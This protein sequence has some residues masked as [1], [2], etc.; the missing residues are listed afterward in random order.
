MKKLRVKAGMG[1][2]NCSQGEE[3]MKFFM[4]LI[5]IFT[6]FCSII[7]AQGLWKYRR[8]PLFSW[9]HNF[10]NLFSLPGTS[11]GW[12][13]GDDII[14]KTTDKGET[15]VRQGVNG[16]LLSVW[17]NTLNTGWTCGYSGKVFYT[18][19]G[20]ATWG[21]GNT[22]ITTN[23]WGIS[24]WDDSTGVAVGGYFGPTTG[25]TIIRTTD[26]GNNWQVVFSCAH[27]LTDVKCIGSDTAWVSAM[28][29]LEPG[30]TVVYR[31]T[32]RGVTWDSIIMVNYNT[33][34]YALEVLN[35]GLTAW[36]L[37]Q[38]SGSPVMVYKTTDA[39]ISWAS[40]NTGIGP[41]PSEIIFMDEQTGWICGGSGQ[42]MMTY[43]A[44]TTDGG[45]SWNICPQPAH[46]TI[47]GVS[48]FD[49]DSFYAVGGMD[50][51]TVLL[52]RDGGDSWYYRAN[53]EFLL[54]L[55]ASDT[56]N[57]WAC[58]NY[59]TMLHSSDGGNTWVNQ[60]SFSYTEPAYPIYA[61]T[62]PTATTGYIGGHGG[63]IRK[64]TDGGQTWFAV[65]GI[66]ARVNNIKFVNPL[67]G[68]AITSSAIY[69]TTDGA[70]SWTQQAVA[71]STMEFNRIDMVDSLYGWVAGNAWGGITTDILYTTDGGANWIP[72]E[73]PISPSKWQDV[74]FLDRDNGY[75]VGYNQWVIKTINNGSTWTTIDLSS[76]T[77]SELYGVA[78][79]DVDHG[80][81][82]THH[83]IL[84]T[85]DGGLT[86]N[87]DSVEASLEFSG[88]PLI[89]CWPV[90]VDSSH[91]WWSD[92]YASPHACILG[93]SSPTGIEEFKPNVKS[94]GLK[95]YPNPFR[96]ITEIRL[97]MTDKQLSDISH[98]SS[99]SIKIYNSSGR[100]VKDFSRTTLNGLCPTH[101]S[102]F[103]KDNSGHQVPA[104]VYF[105][106]L[107][108][109]E[110]SITKKII[111]LK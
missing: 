27:W 72:V 91:A 53:G 97:Q 15:W 93:Y 60:Q 99:V 101:L 13:V 75:M 39:G 59:G 14:A 71:Q 16:I 48:Y 64:T 51:G 33:V 87:K 98:Q 76:Y 26:A 54:A 111:R 50:G 9:P 18:T 85:E 1:V 41:P 103:G 73:P 19:D 31:T 86:W 66:G 29:P 55:A 80:W 78:F 10:Q 107:E 47:R 92:Y 77:T 28:G 23:L 95:I 35:G 56:S 108:L 5:I 105:V 21:T 69:K 32:D 109:T 90:A 7:E 58:G 81:V 4:S 40:Y 68:W 17:F 61:A 45:A 43:I 82:F 34:A 102:W 25:G 65:Q 20:G 100:I 84:H 2:F 63:I 79:G 24:F 52:S 70:G 46:E 42:A 38:Q 37:A 67:I 106:R 57:V 11:T 6:L 22:G 96:Q 36:V 83:C 30:P 49:P 12:A 94:L 88:R 62:F 74:D 110:K 44:K 89:A 104:G 3:K 8:K